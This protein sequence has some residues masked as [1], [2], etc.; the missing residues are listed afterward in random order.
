MPLL[1]NP[2]YA[3]S[4][5][6]KTWLLSLLALCPWASHLTTLVPTSLSVKWISSNTNIA[7]FL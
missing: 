5:Q 2:E 3:E 6:L 4:R 1:E 7:A